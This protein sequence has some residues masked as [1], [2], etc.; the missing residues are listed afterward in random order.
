MIGL[1]LL[2]Q[3]NLLAIQNQQETVNQEMIL[4]LYLLNNHRIPK[5]LAHGVLMLLYVPFFLSFFVILTTTAT[6]LLCIK[7]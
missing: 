5:I 6:T 3:L 2:R 1:F 7:Y 4:I